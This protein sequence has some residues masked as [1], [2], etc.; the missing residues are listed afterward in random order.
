MADRQAIRKMLVEILEEDTGNAYADLA[1]TDSLREGLGLDSVDIV[2]AVSQIERRFKI[3]M[4]HEELGKLSTVADF[5]DLLEAK[6]A[7][8]P[9]ADTA[10]A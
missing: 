10:A 2:S 3:R 5:L 7:Q 8:T 9:G 6:L 1:E 4:T